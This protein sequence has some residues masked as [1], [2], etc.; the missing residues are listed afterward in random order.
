[1]LVGPGGVYAIESKW[2]S[3]LL[4]LS[5]IDPWIAE[6]AR[7]ARAN[8]NDLTLWHELKSLG[9]GDVHPVVFFW[10]PGSSTLPDT[11]EVNDATVVKGSSSK[12]WRTALT[13][14]ALDGNTIEKAWVALDKQC[15][16]RDA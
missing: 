8:A 13:S 11:L 5:P 14:G 12:E 15:R 1:M 10:G 16:L 2:K 9:V 3:D 4:R 7:Q 6:A